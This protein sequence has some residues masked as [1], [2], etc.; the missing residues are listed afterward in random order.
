[1]LSSHFWQVKHNRCFN[2]RS[3][4]RAFNIATEYRVLRFC[5]YASPHTSQRFY[6]TKVY[7]TYHISQDDD[8]NGDYRR[9]Q[10]RQRCMP[11]TS[12][13]IADPRWADVGILRWANVGNVRWANVIL[14]VGPS[15]AQH[16]GA[17]LA[18][19]NPTLAH[20][21][22]IIIQCWPNVGPTLAQ[23]WPKVGSMLG[24]R[25]PNVGLWMCHCWPNIG[26]MLGQR[27]LNVGPTLGY[28]CATISLMLGQHWVMIPIWYP[29]ARFSCLLIYN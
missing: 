7:Q 11:E 27:W 20:R 29:C 15:L 9:K 1:M 4:S 28:G 6:D 26:S 22:Q 25:W 2:T 10:R 3:Q 17:T 14:L 8:Q 23:C 21:W 19:Y 24:H 5:L 18:N 16:I 12:S 13:Q